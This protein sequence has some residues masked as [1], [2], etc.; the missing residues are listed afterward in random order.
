MCLLGLIGS[1]RHDLCKLETPD[2]QFWQFFTN[3]CAWL[4]PC[5]CRVHIHGTCS[6]ACGRATVPV[7][8]PVLVCGHKQ[9]PVVQGWGTCNMTAHSS[10][11]G[12]VVRLC[13]PPPV[14]HLDACCGVLAGLALRTDGGTSPVTAARLRA[15]P[16]ALNLV[17]HAASG[18]FKYFLRKG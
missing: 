11:S 4:F 17:S 18:V 13:F 2:E 1:E 6:T 10:G 8:L 9:Q 16:V 14:T 7:S 5:F 12:Q 3:L 15:V